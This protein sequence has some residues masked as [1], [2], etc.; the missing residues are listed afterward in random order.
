MTTLEGP[1]LTSD[2]YR[3]DQAYRAL[4]DAITRMAELNRLGPADIGRAAGEAS[5]L[6]TAFEEQRHHDLTERM[7]RRL[8]DFQVLAAADALLTSQP[9]R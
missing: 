8:E 7:K 4:V 1:M 5:T 9:W 6:V 2:R 3:T